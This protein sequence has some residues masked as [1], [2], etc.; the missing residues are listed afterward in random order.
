MTTDKKLQVAIKKLKEALKHEEEAV[1]NELVFDSICKRYEVCFEYTWK[2]LKSKVDETGVE[3]YNPRD[4]IREAHKAGYVDDLD[5][6][7][8]FLKSRNM[9]VHDY[10]GFADLAY[11]KNIS[12]FYEA[13]QALLS[14]F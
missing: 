4:V 7:L 2:F 6:W 14:S 1:T 9:S 13:V 10:I 11:L 3:V 5:L 8:G 12:K